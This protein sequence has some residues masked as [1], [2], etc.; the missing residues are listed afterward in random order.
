MSRTRNESFYALSDLSSLHS[1][2]LDALKNNGPLTRGELSELTG[3]RL[4]SIF[5]R[6]N[7]LLES[8]LIEGFGTKFD[9]NTRRNVQVLRI[10]NSYGPFL[11]LA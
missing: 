11:R 8:K 4:S 6:A 3:I 10:R 1:K 5:G 7:E 2:V 9:E